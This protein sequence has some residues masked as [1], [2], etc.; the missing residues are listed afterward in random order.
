MNLAQVEA[1]LVLAE[2]C[3]FGRTADRLHV[4]QPRVSR[5][6]AA[7][8]REAGGTLFERTSRRVEL[9]PLGAQL[10]DG[11]QPGYAQLRGAL[12]EARAAARQAAGQ[13]RVG[14]TVLTGGQT[15]TRLLDAFAAAHPGCQVAV[16]EVSLGDPY[17]AL[18]R[19]RVDVVF[20][21]LAVGEPDLTAG[22]AVEYLDRV[23][24]VARHHRLAARP[25]V[26][27]E[28]LGDYELARPEPPMPRTLYDAIVPPHTPSGR[29]TR[30]TCIIRSLPEPFALVASGRIVHPTFTCVPLAHRDDISLVPLAGLPPMARGPIWC[31]ARQNARIRALAQ[32]AATLAP[33]GAASTQA[34]QPHSQAREFDVRPCLPACLAGALVAGRRDTHG[35]SVQQA[36]EPECKALV[37]GQVGPGGEVPGG[38]CA[39]AG[40]LGRLPAGRG[41]LQRSGCLAPRHEKLPGRLALQEP[42]DVIVDDGQ[43]VEF[44]RRIE[45]EPFER[46]QRH[47]AVPHRLRPWD[48][49]DAE[50][51]EPQV[52]AARGPGGPGDGRKI[53]APVARG[54]ARE[55]DLADDGVDHEL[56]QLALVREVPVERGRRGADASGEVAHRYCP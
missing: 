25:S 48:R 21:L 38:D 33:P 20:N 16:T 14:C 29:P 23:L 27:A 28:D 34:R 22:P 49:M 31:T 13:L 10:R 55:L 6:V 44:S 24:A 9:T 4:S 46:S 54:L 26:S 42:G 8:E 1:F 40:P 19:G 35:D 12:A 52:T 11:W 43:D 7:L 3:H 56:V 17:A 36:V 53:S 15:L 39:V 30:R 5:L 37:G 32:V 50:L 2:E 41:V 45:P 18:R 51:S 47:L